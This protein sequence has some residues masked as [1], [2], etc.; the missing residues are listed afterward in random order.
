MNGRSDAGPTAASAHDHGDRIELSGLVVRGTHGV[1]EHERR[2][3]Q[4]FVIDLVIWADL[5]PAGRSD[6]LA[7]TIDYG[8]VADAVV[9]VVGGPP[10]DLIETVAHRIS[11]RVLATDPRIGRVRV[12]VHKPE[13]PIPHRFGDVAVVITRTATSAT[14]PS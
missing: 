6:D 14:V 11:D 3:G 4:D 7:D 5:G 1:F 12:T 13:A 8:G 2:D 9:E 10:V